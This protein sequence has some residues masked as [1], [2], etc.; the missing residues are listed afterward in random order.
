[1]TISR[2][3]LTVLVLA[4]GALLTAPALGEHQGSVELPAGFP[5]LRDTVDPDRP[6]SIVPTNRDLVRGP[7]YQPLGLNLQS[8][9]L[10]SELL[11]DAQ[12][13]GFGAFR[14]VIR[15]ADFSEQDSPNFFK[16]RNVVACMV[17]QGQE[18]LLTLE[19]ARI[20][21]NLYSAYFIR[22]YN[23]VSDQVRYYQLADNINQHVGLS[24]GDYAETLSLIRAFRDSQK[25]D[26]K[27]VLGGIRGIDH[28]F[29]SKL[30]EQRILGR[31]DVLAFNL[32]P[33][34][35]HM[36][37]PYAGRELA[38]MSL[39]SA[40]AAFH[41]LAAYGKP[42]YITDLGV[43]TAV[44]PLGV[45]QLDQASM[46]SRSTLYLLNGGASRV[47]LHSLQDTEANLVNPQRN[48]GL[49]TH[50]GSTKPAYYT[51]QRLTT[52]LRGAYFFE[53]YFTFEMTNE[54]PARGDPLFAYFL[55]RPTDRATCFIYWTSKMNALDRFTN[56][57]IYRPQLEVRSMMNLLSGE[58]GDVPCRRAKNLLLF[59]R[60]PLSHIPTFIVMTGEEP[61]G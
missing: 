33:D 13:L 12:K 8:E 49:L 36:E 9:L 52:V 6:V 57:M 25:A 51:M 42:I 30:G 5:P 58:S 55:Y 61:D 35:N 40:V 39:C 46:L 59:H 34:P 60:L 10:S 48:M 56:L 50:D 43:S 3:K 54:F 32:Y 37:L 24:T 18:I 23:A 53:P 4:F 26:F 15:E 11:A 1:M 28:A 16:L 19:S 41:D 44:S 20:S 29:I 22:I 38:G 17:S 47:F 14:L 7:D 45:S 27:L 31:V 21:P 2:A